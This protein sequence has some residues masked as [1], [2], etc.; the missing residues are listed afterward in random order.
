MY[1]I[2][3]MF[4]ACSACRFPSTLVHCLR[5]ESGISVDTRATTE[6]A[7]GLY[8]GV[9]TASGTGGTAPLGTG[10]RSTCDWPTSSGTSAPGTPGGGNGQFS[11]PRGAGALQRAPATRPVRP[12]VHP[13]L[14]AVLLDHLVDPVGRQGPRLP[15]SSHGPRRAYLSASVRTGGA[16]RMTAIRHPEEDAVLAVCFE[17]SCRESQPCSA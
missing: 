8:P 17:R 16:P 15:V 5:P 2:A 1:F 7:G 4:R 13:G 14:L 9:P 10:R 11:C 6:T 3:K 12:H